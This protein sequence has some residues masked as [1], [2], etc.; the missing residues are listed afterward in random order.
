MRHISV[1][2]FVLVFLLLFGTFAELAV[3]IVRAKGMKLQRVGEDMFWDIRSTSWVAPYIAAVV[4]NKYMI[5]YP[6]GAFRPKQ[7]V[8]RA[9]AAVTLARA[10][11]L[12]QD[13]C[14]D[15]IF[16]D[17]P[18]QHW[19]CEAIDGAD[20]AG[21]LKYLAN[22]DFEPALG[23]TRAEAAEIISRIPAVRKR[24]DKALCKE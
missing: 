16:P 8:S 5:G 22:K 24:I 9:E 2:I 12:F 13:K 11:D 14:E 23:L 1:L 4:N 19:A 7:M 6:D 20:K 17:I 21:L 10:F 3:L 15:N 18:R